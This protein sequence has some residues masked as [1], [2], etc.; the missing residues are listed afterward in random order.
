VM[1]KPP[2]HPYPKHKG[3]GFRKRFFCLN[4]GMG[5]DM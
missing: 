2:K 5:F 1:C 4:R 3:M